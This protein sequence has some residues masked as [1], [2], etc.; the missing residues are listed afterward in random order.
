[1]RSEKEPNRVTAVVELIKQQV[2]QRVWLPGERIPSIR[3]MSKLQSIS[4]MTVMKAYEQLELDGWIYAKPQ[5]GYYVS[6]HFNQLKD[7]PSLQPQIVN[8]SIRINRHV[9]D[10]MK[11][12]KQPDVIP[13]GSAFPDPS[14][15]PQSTLGRLLSRVV[16]TMPSH[17]GITDLSPGC[18]TLRRAI[19]QRYAKVGVAV[20]AEQIVVTSGATEAL[21]LGLSAVTQPGDMVAVES[22]V[23]YG[24]LQ[25]IERLHLKVVEIPACP[26]QGINIEALASCIER[27]PIKACWLMSNFQNPTGASL[28]PNRQRALYELLATRNIAMIEDD[29]YGELYY[30]PDKPVSLKSIDSEGMVIHCS[31]FSKSLAPGFRVGWTLAGRFTQQVAELQFM[32]TLSAPVPNQHAIASYIKGGGYDGHLRQLRR[33][34]EARQRQMREAILCLFPSG[35]KVTIPSG[36]YF[37]WVVLPFDIDSAALLF[38]LLE[39]YRISIAPGTLFS[40]DSQYRHCMRFNCSYPLT[41]EYYEA[42][43]CIAQQVSTNSH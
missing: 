26:R 11:A 35:T 30:G 31:S 3:K 16:K 41:P 18:L 20:G 17:S 22:P 27:Y 15:F 38:I 4:P 37:L 40:S 9:F 25:A 33:T 39:R 8:Q 13:F 5:S 28:S 36:G 10:V 6:A 42:L 24:A 14:L 23:F 7:M 19:S 12:I 43:R 21:G 32:S 29:V 1:M 34:L 2:S